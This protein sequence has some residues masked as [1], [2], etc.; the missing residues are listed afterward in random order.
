M[1][2]PHI[3]KQFIGID[4]VV[5]FPTIRINLYGSFAISCNTSLLSEG[6]C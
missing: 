2:D 4:T 3:A 6:Q 1:T 5:E